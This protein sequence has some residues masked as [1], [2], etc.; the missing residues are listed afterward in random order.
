MAAM[1]HP[2]WALPAI[3]LVVG[4]ILAAT[5]LWQMARMLLRPPRMNDGRAIYLL[6]RL[7]PMDLDL[8]FEEVWFEGAGVK[9]AGWWIPAKNPSDKCIVLIHGYGDAKVGAIAWA[10]LL[11]DLGWN[12]L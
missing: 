6:K 12:V 8:D 7:S 5:V 11:H 2:F 1:G 10:P 3:L 4:A 9:I